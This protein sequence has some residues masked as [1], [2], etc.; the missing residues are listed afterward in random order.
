MP[1]PITISNCP[2]SLI[3][4]LRKITESFDSSPIL[5]FDENSKDESKRTLNFS[6]FDIRVDEIELA[7]D[8][9]WDALGEEILKRIVAL[10]SV[11]EHKS[12]DEN[13]L[14]NLWP[15]PVKMFKE[16]MAVALYAVQ[17]ASIVSRELQ[18]ALGK[19]TAI[20]KNDK[21]PV[22]IADFTVQAIILGI[23][24]KYYPNDGFIAEE[25][26]KVL[27]EDMSTFDEVIKL[28]QKVINTDCTAEDVCRWIDLGAKGGNMSPGCRTWVLDPIDG[29]KGFI[30]GGQFCL[31]LGMLVG[32]E[33]ALGVLG[34][35]VLPAD[36]ADLDNANGTSKRGQLLYAVK[37]GGAFRRFIGD[38]GGISDE[39]KTHT[40]NKASDGAVLESAESAHTSH[41]VAHD[42]CQDLKI[43]LP[44]YR[45]D[46]QCKYACLAAGQG[47]IYLRMPRWGYRENIWD[48][49]A[50]AVVIEEAGGK[51]TDSM[52]VPLDFSQG[53]TL[54]PH[55]AGIVATS[56]PIHGEVIAVV[57]RN[58]GRDWVAACKK[59]DSAKWK[60]AGPGPKCKVP[61]KSYGTM[62]P[63]S[64]DVMIVCDC[65]LA[66]R[67]G[68]TS[69][70]ESIVERI[71]KAFP[72]RGYWGED[73]DCGIPM[74]SIYLGGRMIWKFRLDDEC[75][76]K[77]MDAVQY[78]LS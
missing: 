12:T 13:R 75:I 77:G 67:E 35:P 49:V 37:N 15:P 11:S 5:K 66:S 48:H 9:N 52:G 55:V 29:T 21:S 25:S 61:I 70:I 47:S 73:I 74:V 65:S 76:E 8:V 71:P 24:S 20:S 40:G 10:N 26:S 68:I 59:A 34:C 64:I 60:G 54:P 78:I 7:N 38:F 6:K 1:S 23:I 51:V 32:G 33:G 28:I 27:M 46:S 69:R 17:L 19:R 56:G 58:L 41:G 44:P 42:V 22:T 72:A 57:G 53:T 14:R 31:A 63:S 50:G 45:M 4:N 39:I 43:S 2:Q 62:E 30:R 16:E 18:K 36:L 3:E